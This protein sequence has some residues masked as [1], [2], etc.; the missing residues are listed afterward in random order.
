[1]DYTGG[2]LLMLKKP[3]YEELED[4]VN[5]LEEENK[6]LKRE[7]DEIQQNSKIITKD[8]VATSESIEVL[9]NIL[10]NPNI[11]LS[12]KET[13]SIKMVVVFLNAILKNLYH[14]IYY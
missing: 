10:D 5:K 4:A 3:T 13:F 7:N 2:T 8:F 1:M 14:I 11:H 6:I 9:E 12:M